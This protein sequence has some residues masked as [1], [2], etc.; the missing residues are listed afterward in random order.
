VTAQRRPG[1]P[2][3]VDY[4]YAQVGGYT[5]AVR[6]GRVWLHPIHDGPVDGDM[7]AA[8]ALALASALQGAAL[9]AKRMGRRPR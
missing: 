8:T 1:P 4:L 2:V 7:N 3:V 6:D 5:V 9:Q